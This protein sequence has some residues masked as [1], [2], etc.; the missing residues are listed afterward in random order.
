MAISGKYQQEPAAIRLP[1]AVG[2][3]NDSVRVAVSGRRV[4]SEAAHAYIRVDPDFAV[5]GVHPLICKGLRVFYPYRLV[6]EMHTNEK[7][8]PVLPEFS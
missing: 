2:P 7:S 8:P 6:C 1:R 3:R 4:V 5:L